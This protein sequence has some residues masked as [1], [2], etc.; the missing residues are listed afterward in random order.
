MVVRL[1][2]SET[3]VSEIG[4]GTIAWGDKAKGYDTT[5]A[6]RDLFA[7]VKYLAN[8]GVNFF[9]CAEVYGRSAAEN[10]LGDALAQP[11]MP[12]GAVLSTKFFPLPWTAIVGVGGGVRLGRQAVRE[13]LRYSLTRLGAASVDL[14]YIHFPFPLPG[15]VD[16]MADCVDAGLVRHVGVSNYNRQQLKDVHAAFAARNVRL[17]SNQFRFNILDRS[18]EISGLLEETLSLGVTPV[19]YEPL[20][21]G[22]LTGKYTENETSPGSKYTLQQLKLVKQL[23]NLMKFV[24]AV[25]GRGEPRSITEVALAYCISKG[26]VAIPGIKNEGQA[27]EA[28]RAL[29]WAMSRDIVETLDEK[30]D[31]IVRQQGRMRS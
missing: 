10:I 25:G 16:G 19:A 1:G 9:D 26:V 27:R 24:G 7:A 11:E 6:K 8:N 30:S 4:C 5:F 12:S 29:N 31:Y 23:T 28:V 20:A 17:A 14:Y 2:E 13:A 22:L 21:Q 15:L 18:A 3:Y